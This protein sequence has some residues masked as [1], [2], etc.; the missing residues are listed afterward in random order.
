MGMK[1]NGI[2]AHAPPGLGAVSI[3]ANMSATTM[4]RI[5]AARPHGTAVLVAPNADK[6]VSVP[7][8]CCNTTTTSTNDSRAAAPTPAAAPAAAAPTA[9]K[10][11]WNTTSCAWPYCNGP[12]SD[13]GAP[14]RVRDG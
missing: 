11:M 13:H 12:E 1:K 14:I 7:S 10:F 8:G 6:R 2:I 5:A 9:G 4:A 3:I